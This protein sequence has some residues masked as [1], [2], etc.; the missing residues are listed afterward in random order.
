[1]TAEGPKEREEE[2][3]RGEKTSAKKWKR[4]REHNSISLGS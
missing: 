2:G 1:M 3:E 4:K